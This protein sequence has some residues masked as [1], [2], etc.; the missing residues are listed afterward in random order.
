MKKQ[1][2]DDTHGK[3]QEIGDGQWHINF[4][5][6]KATNAI[7]NNNGCYALQLDTQDKQKHSTTL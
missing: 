7:L 4:Q 6:R 2:T 3:S 5:T 1:E